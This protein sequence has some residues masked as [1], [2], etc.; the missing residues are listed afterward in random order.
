MSKNILQEKFED[1][2]SYFSESKEIK[3]S[4][5]IK[6]CELCRQWIPI[7]NPA[8]TITA[9]NGDYF[10]FDICIPCTKTHANEIAAMKSGDYDM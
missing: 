4:R 3:K 9:F 5:K 10:T 7:G 8:L 6:L 2:D 1:T